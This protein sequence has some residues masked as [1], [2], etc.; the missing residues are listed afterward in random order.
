MAS[1]TMGR[2]IIMP[3]MMRSVGRVMMP[4][5]MRMWWTV[6]GCWGVM[7]VMGAAPVSWGMMMG[8][9]V[10]WM[11]MPPTRNTGPIGRGRT[12]VVTTVV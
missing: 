9:M 10:M 12:A 7:S 6:S 11:R 3:A 4:R 2:I 5:V 1:M 8:C